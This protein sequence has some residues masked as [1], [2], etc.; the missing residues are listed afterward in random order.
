MNN[1]EEG[2]AHGMKP[3]RQACPN[4]FHILG[5]ETKCERS[6]GK[7]RGPRVRPRETISATTPSK[8]LESSFFVKKSPLEGAAEL[9]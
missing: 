6:E 4:E 3:S 7:N 1:P 2:N 9:D 5:A 8:L